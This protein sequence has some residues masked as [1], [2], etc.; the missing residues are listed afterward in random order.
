MT[1]HK[2]QSRQGERGSRRFA[3]KTGFEKSTRARLFR[4]RIG[5]TL[6]PPLSNLYCRTRDLEAV[7][8]APIYQPPLLLFRHPLIQHCSYQYSR[9][10]GC[11]NRRII[12]AL[13]GPTAKDPIGRQ[14]RE[15]A[16]G[17]PPRDS[18]PSLGTA[19]CGGIGRIG[20]A[21]EAAT[22]ARTRRAAD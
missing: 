6:L 9:H 7:L 12:G 2:G 3:L 10:R 15:G 11:D 18:V 4:T 14:V 5:P 16:R 17:R 19:N 21:E 13:F 1:R 20:K 22:C 8:G